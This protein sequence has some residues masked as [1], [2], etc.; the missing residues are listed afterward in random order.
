MT[1]L[2]DVTVV[3][4]LRFSDPRYWLSRIDHDWRAVP[5]LGDL[6]AVA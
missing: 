4:V 6:F 3:A 5:L 2:C 1:W